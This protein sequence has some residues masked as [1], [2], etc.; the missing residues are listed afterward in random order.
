[1]AQADVGGD[2]VARVGLLDE[3]KGGAFRAAHGHAGAARVQE[4]GAP[5]DGGEV[6]LQGT[7]PAG[8]ATHHHLEGEAERESE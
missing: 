8:T 2:G 7:P 1:V 6:I 4:P 3:G 5:V